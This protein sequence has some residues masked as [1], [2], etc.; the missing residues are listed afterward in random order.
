MKA[1][2]I[3]PRTGMLSMSLRLFDLYAVCGCILVTAPFEL[4]YVRVEQLSCASVQLQNYQHQ[5]A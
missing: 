4:R 2:R 3:D 1:S 5:V